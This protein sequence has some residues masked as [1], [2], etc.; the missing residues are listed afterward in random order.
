MVADW[1]RPPSQSPAKPND[2][3]LYNIWTD[4]WGLFTIALMLLILSGTV[5]LPAFLSS[6]QHS[7]NSPGVKA[8]YA[9]AAILATIFHH[10]T[11]GYGAYQHWSLPSHHNRAMDV[12][13]YGC[14]FF[15]VLGVAAMTVGMKGV[16]GV[17]GKGRK[18]V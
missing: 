5:P 6:Q 13:V 16:D 11:T 17:K 18:R 9:K 14:A 12:G 7:S 8:P 1:F 15:A 3:E 2:L 10:V 4:A